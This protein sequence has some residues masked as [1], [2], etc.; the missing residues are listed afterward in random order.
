MSR[1]RFLSFPLPAAP[2]RWPVRFAPAP[3]VSAPAVAQPGIVGPRVI[4]P[5]R[6][7]PRIGRPLIARP[8]IVRPDTRTD[9]RP[10]VEAK[11]GT[12]TEGILC[13]GL[14]I[15]LETGQTDR[16][17][18]IILDR[19]L[20]GAYPV[21]T[22]IL[23]LRPCADIDADSRTALVSLQHRLASAGTRLRITTSCRQL[24]RCLGEAG[25]RR[26][27]GP[28]AIHDSFRA[29]VLATYAARPGPGLV[30]AQV[31]AALDTPVEAVGS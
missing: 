20:G 25:L 26:Y 21:G 18:D 12:G 31:R 1:S 19:V 17:A 24:A 15:S 6:G 4:R 30:T 29:A 22:V 3:A 11:T 16:L 28:D 8:H 5:R 7:R 10:E 23:D 27:L 13:L 2:V 14:S 9:R